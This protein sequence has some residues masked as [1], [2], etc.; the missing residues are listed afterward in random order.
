MTFLI[1]SSLAFAIAMLGVGVA[2][3]WTPESRD[4]VAEEIRNNLKR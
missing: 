1:A 4:V 2:L 3:E